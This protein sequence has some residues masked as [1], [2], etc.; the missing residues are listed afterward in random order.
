MYYDGALNFELE[1]QFSSK[2]RVFGIVTKRN[3]TLKKD[4]RELPFFV[5]GSTF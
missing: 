3:K 2:D 4:P 1:K 5:W